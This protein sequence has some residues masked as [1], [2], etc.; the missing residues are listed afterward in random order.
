MFLT[1]AAESLPEWAAGETVSIRAQMNFPK[2][3][4]LFTGNWHPVEMEQF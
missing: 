4:L 2:I 1:T 3:W